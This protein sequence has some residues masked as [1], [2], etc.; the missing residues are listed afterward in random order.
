MINEINTA[1]KVYNYLIENVK[2]GF[3][4]KNGTKFIRKDISEVKYMNNL[5]NHYYYQS[6]FELNQSKCGLCFDQIEFA[7]YVL[8]GNGYDVKTFYTKICNHVFL[9]YRLGNKYYY[10]DTSIPYFKGIY[11]FNSLEE[12]FTYYVSK[13]N[14]DKYDEIDFYNYKNIP[15]GCDFYD[16][17]NNIRNQNDIQMTLK[18]KKN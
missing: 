17:I 4:S 8:Y 12:L 16:F 14:T 6:P 3:V 1:E 7:R 18:L 11:S 15:Y 10:F 5:F 2:Y 13:Q 9:V